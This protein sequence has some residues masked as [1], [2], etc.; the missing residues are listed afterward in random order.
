MIL[1]VK[2]KII[3]ASNVYQASAEDFVGMILIDALSQTKS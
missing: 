2:L 1:R 3:L